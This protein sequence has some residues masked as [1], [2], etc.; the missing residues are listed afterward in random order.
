MASRTTGIST[1]AER[2]A[3]ALYELA[4]G[5]R[6]L[7]ATAADLKAV[8]GLLRSSEDLS[9]LVRSP[10]IGRDEQVKAMAAVLE[11]AGVSSLARRF[12]GV[13]GRNRRLFALDAIVGAFLR[14]LAERRGDVSVVVR[15]AK[16]LDR[17]QEEALKR[18]LRPVAGDRVRLEVA[19]DP[20]VLGGLVVQV[21]SR[22]YDS[23]LKT[24]LE[25]LQLAMKGAV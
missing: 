14:L 5:A 18:A 21:G 2:Y 19:V 15:S 23:S 1:I 24:K 16:A 4:D 11:R 7:D 10:V 8:S 9:R 25:R 3:V 22:M 12:V 13:V 17:D 20:A 6:A